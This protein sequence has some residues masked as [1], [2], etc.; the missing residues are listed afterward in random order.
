MLAVVGS[1]AVDLGLHFP[2]SGF[3]GISTLEAHD[4]AVKNGSMGGLLAV[5]SFLEV[6]RSIKIFSDDDW[7]PGDFGLDPFKMANEKQYTAELKN[8]RLAMLAFS[9]L[10]TQTALTGHGFPYN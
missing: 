5:V 8:G 10:I 1:I 4:F 2:G 9:G 7:V 6:L 3:E